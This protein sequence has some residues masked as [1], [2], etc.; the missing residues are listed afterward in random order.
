M[1]SPLSGPPAV[2]REM[3]N[4]LVRKG[5]QPSVL[6]MWSIYREVR[7]KIPAILKRCGTPSVFQA[8]VFEEISFAANVGQGES[9]GEVSGKHV[10]RPYSLK[11]ETPKGAPPDSKGCA[12]GPGKIL[13][14]S[15]ASVCQTRAI[16]QRFP[17][18]ARVFHQ[19]YVVSSIAFRHWDQ[20][21]R[22]TNWMFSL[23]R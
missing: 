23:E 10:E 20:R 22:Y 9:S 5:R 19:G 14:I 15:F 2:F 13:A 1:R 7:G 18:F 21:G 16:W 17:S 3:G 6:Q 8:S 12:T 4:A 11:N